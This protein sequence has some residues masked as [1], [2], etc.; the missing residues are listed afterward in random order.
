MLVLN[1]LGQM[2]LNRFARLDVDSPGHAMLL[3]ADGYWLY[4]TAEGRTWGFMFPE[5][6]DDVF[7]QRLWPGVGADARRPS[8]QFRTAAGLFTFE[9]VY[10]FRGVQSLDRSADNVLGQL[11]SSLVCRVIGQPRSCRSTWPS[12]VAGC[13]YCRCC[14]W[15]LSPASV[16]F[17]RAMPWPAKSPNRLSV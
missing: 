4:D 1:Y 15:G 12:C 7:E 10:P 11:R 16:G 5:R 2:V 14:C 3:N 9:T 17:W 6:V 8:G 13:G